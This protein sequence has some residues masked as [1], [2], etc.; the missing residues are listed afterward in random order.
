MKDAELKL[1]KQLIDAQ[2]SETFDPT[3]YTDEVAAR[4]RSAVEKKVEGQ[5][6]TMSEAPEAAA[7]AR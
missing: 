7:A 2:S 1:A 5:E 3:A 6:I 4:I